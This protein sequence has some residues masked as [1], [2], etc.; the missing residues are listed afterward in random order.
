MARY[1]S[2][3]VEIDA[4]QWWGLST[5]IAPEWFAKAGLDGL[6]E[7]LPSGRAEILTPEGRMQADTSWWIIRGTE[8][9]IY[10]CKDS[11]FQ[12]KYEEVE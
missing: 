5:K 11:V 2:K 9:E 7:I 1:R 10:P 12:R 3:V 6:V 8:G 4:F